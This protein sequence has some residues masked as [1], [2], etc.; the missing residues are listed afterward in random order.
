M[1]ASRAIGPG[2]HQ[3]HVP[4]SRMVA[5][6]K[7]ARTTVASRTTAMPI[8][9]PTA[10]MITESAKAKAKKTAAMIAPAHVMSRPVRSS[11]AP[12]ARMLSPVRSYSSR[13]RLKS[14]TS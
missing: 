7:R 9:T 5:G 4:M 6:T 3:F 14:S 1:R 11:P 2:T 10:L 12:T 13:T 8:P